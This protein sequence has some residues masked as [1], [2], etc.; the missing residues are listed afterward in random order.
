MVYP[1]IHIC[2]YTY[3][4]IY[5]AYCIFQALA[6]FPL[7][8]GRP[9]HERQ[10]AQFAT[11]RDGDDVGRAADGEIFEDRNLAEL[12]GPRWGPRTTGK[13]SRQH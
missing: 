9:E 7:A 6:I 12:R 13:P 11:S 8:R 4:H 1:Y 10:G 5:I 3:I 2:I